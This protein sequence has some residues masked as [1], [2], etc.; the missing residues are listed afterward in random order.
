MR[1]TSSVA[2]PENLRDSKDNSLE[3]AYPS[4][5]PNWRVVELWGLMQRAK[6]AKEI[7]NDELAIEGWALGHRNVARIYLVASRGTALW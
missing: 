4:E 2:R 5:H 6:V 1:S 3:P 7:P